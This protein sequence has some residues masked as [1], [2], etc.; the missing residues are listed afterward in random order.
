MKERGIEKVDDSALRALC[1]ELLAA[2]PRIVADVKAGKE[3]AAGQLV[4]QAKKK[5][6]NV[7]P[8]EVRAICLELIKGM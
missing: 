4:G 1:A 3:Q 5:N 2:N 7:N 6:P 8:A